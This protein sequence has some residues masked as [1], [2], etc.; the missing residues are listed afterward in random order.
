MTYIYAMF[1]SA[2]I[3]GAVFFVSTVN[4]GA[5]AERI[6]RCAAFDDLMGPLLDN[7][8]MQYPEGH[9]CAKYID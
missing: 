8:G 1:A 2:V 7:A 4:A 3:L 5:E 9:A 6:E